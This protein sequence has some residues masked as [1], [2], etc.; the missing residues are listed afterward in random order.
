VWCAASI[1]FCW[2]LIAPLHDTS[3]FARQ[4]VAVNVMAEDLEMQL[5]SVLAHVPGEMLTYVA[6]A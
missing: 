2:L 4:Q 5:L 3:A 6:D 1:N